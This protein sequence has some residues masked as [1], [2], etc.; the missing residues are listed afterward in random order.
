MRIYIN[1]ICIF[2]LMTMTYGIRVLQNKMQE[3]FSFW[4]CSSFDSIQ[5]LNKI[6]YLILNVKMEENL[7]KSN[8]KKPNTSNS[9]QDTMASTFCKHY[10]LSL[11]VRVCVCVWKSCHDKCQKRNITVTNI[12]IICNFNS[13]LPKIDS[14]CVCVCV[15]W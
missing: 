11:C 2:C 15:F 9:I 14:Q 1:N 12:S 10:V 4:L 3:T 13:I 6:F 8:V 7:K 5:A